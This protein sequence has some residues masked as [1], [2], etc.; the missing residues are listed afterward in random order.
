VLHLTALG[1]QHTG[2]CTVAEPPAQSPV[3]V[4]PNA[5]AEHRRYGRMATSEATDSLRP[6]EEKEMD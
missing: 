2:D 6:A 3:S 5:A 4:L 1:P